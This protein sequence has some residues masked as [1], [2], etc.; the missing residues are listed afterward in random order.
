VGPVL[1]TVRQ[2]ATL[3][4]PKLGEMVTLQCGPEALHWF[5]AKTQHRVAA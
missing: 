3:P 2:D 4:P 5:D 1:F